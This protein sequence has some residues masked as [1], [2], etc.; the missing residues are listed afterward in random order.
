VLNFFKTNVM[1][2]TNRTLLAFVGGALAGA[3]IGVLLAP[4][5]GSAL[6]GKIM[7]RAKDM[8]DDLAEAADEKYQEFISWKNRM[9]DKAEEGVEN[10]KEHV[11]HM[12]DQAKEQVDRVKR[13]AEDQVD[14]AKRAAHRGV[15]NGAD[16]L[17]RNIQNT[18]PRS[19]DL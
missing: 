17:K 2:N 10:V 13:T 15:E 3:A 9:R 7:D 6:R 18:P 8:T 4:D 16:G 1:N 19:A 5:K 12:K 11:N 14:N